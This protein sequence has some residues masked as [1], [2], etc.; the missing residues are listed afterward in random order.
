MKT[1]PES[2]ASAFATQL[3]HLAASSAAPKKEASEEEVA[4]AKSRTFFI[5]HA[6]V[7]GR[8]KTTDQVS[9]E[10]GTLRPTHPDS[11]DC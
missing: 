4:Q 6:V 8:L 5:A 3:V 7:D 9:G 11:I 1:S 2:D 10:E